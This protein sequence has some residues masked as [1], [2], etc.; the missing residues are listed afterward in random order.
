MNSVEKAFR[1]LLLNFRKENVN[2]NG[3]KF[4]EHLNKTSNVRVNVTLRCVLGTTVS[5]QKQ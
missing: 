1:G 2:K 3:I 4:L 5:A